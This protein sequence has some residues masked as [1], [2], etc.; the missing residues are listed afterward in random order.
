[1]LKLFLYLVYNSWSVSFL[2]I[3][4]NFY[5]NIIKDEGQNEHITNPSEGA[6]LRCF[7]IEVYLKCWESSL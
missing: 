7:V 5:V 3:S 2:S 6:V 4:H 1:M